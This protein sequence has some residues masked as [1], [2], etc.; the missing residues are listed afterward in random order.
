MA[1]PIGAIVGAVKFAKSIVDKRAA[2]RK[3]RRE[4]RQSGE[5]N[6]REARKDRR[7]DRKE[8]KQEAKK[9]RK[10]RIRKRER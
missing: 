4:L 10:N 3:E 5:L 6:R 7:Q 2:D 9:R 1:V 8:R